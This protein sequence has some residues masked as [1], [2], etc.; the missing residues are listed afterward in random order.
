[1]KGKRSFIGIGISLAVFMLLSIWGVE[2][3]P[4]AECQLI[5][6]SNQVQAANTTAVDPEV[7]Y[8]SKG[9]CV[10]WANMSKDMIRVRFNG[11]IQCAINPVGFDCKEKDKSFVSGYFGTGESRS[12]E[13]V[14]AGTYQYEIQL[15]SEPSVK[16]TGTIIVE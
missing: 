16:T 15:K 14:K 7:L 1:M 8:I 6:I 4:A 12:L 5:K 13:I 10:F 9:D 11:S 3:V 2:K